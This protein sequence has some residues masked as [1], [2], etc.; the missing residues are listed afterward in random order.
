MADM[1][2]EADIRSQAWAKTVTGFGLQSYVLKNLC[3]VNTTSAWSNSYFI[4]TAADLTASGTRNVDG[5][6]RLAKFPNADVS[7][8]EAT[9]RLGKFGCSTTLSYEDV[10]TDRV[11]VIARSLLRIGRAVALAVDK[12]IYAAMKAATTNTVTIAAGSEWDSATIS[13]RDPIQ[14]IL[15]AKKEIFKDN[16]DANT[17][18]YLVLCPK[19]Y[20]NLLGNSNVRNVGAFYSADV[21]KKG[22]VGMLLGLKVVV[23]NSVTEADEKAFVAIAKES[24]TWQQQKALTTETKYEAGRYYR[25]T[26][27]EIGCCQVTNP[28]AICVIDNTQK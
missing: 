26:A 14:N 13:K 2:G 12:N 6:A 25:V 9:K 16:Y 22:E 23:T 4:E 3:A 11:D 15:D 5:V 21:T 27:F 17:N 19:D 10:H 18:G 7:W 1:S 24:M 8:T 28:L 20:A